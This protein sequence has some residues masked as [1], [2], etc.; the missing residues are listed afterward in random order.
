MG[1]GLPASEP[2]A[3]PQSRHSPQVV[4]GSRAPAGQRFELAIIV[5]NYRTPELTIDCL[6][7]LAGEVGHAAIEAIVLD[8]ASGDGSVEQIEQEIDRAGWD[9]WARLVCADENGGFSAG[10][11]IGVA[12]ADA[13]VYLFLNSDTIVRPGAVACLLEAVHRTRGLVGAQLE[14]SDGTPQENRRAYLRPLHE[15]ARGAH[16]SAVSPHLHHLPGCTL[17]VQGRPRAHQHLGQRSRQ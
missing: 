14:A 1:E 11:N 10:N 3:G 8:N 7:S 4:P 2:G 5:L 6:R 17:V 16:T 15:L 9:G 13:D 12:A